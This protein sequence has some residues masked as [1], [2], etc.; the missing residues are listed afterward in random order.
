MHTIVWNESYSV[1]VGE[2]DEQ[3]KQLV[4]MINDFI[5]HAEDQEGGVELCADTLAAMSE[6]AATH[7][8]TE[9]ALLRAHGFQ[10]LASH[11]TEHLSF[12]SEIVHLGDEIASYGA[13]VPP[14][15]RNRLGRYLRDWLSNHI[16]HTDMGYKGFFAEKGVR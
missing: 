15:A 1:G 8:A 9:E 11:Q 12:R 2:L 7:F 13:A 4:N 14:E 3:H 16:L 5:V 6:Y 10:Q